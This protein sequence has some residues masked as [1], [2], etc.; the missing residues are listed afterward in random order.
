MI[1]QIHTLYYISLVHV[2]CRQD[3]VDLLCKGNNCCYNN[4]SKH[5][6][7]IMYMNELKITV[8]QNTQDLL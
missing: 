4:N 8:I 7:K 6:M 5:L 2:S 1:E 3:T